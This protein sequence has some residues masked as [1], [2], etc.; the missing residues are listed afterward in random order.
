MHAPKFF[1]GFKA[2]EP[3]HANVQNDK[4]RGNIPCLFKSLYSV[5]R[6]MNVVFP[7]E[8][9]FDGIADVPTVVCNKYTFHGK[10]R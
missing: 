4:I 1:H 3:R 7:L 10:P 6:N 5:M 9:Q 2:V 8:I